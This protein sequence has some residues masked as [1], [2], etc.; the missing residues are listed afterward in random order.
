[1]SVNVTPIAG[2]MA[3]KVGRKVVTRYPN[4]CQGT[5]RRDQL[6]KREERLHALDSTDAK[7][8]SYRSCTAAF[9]G[10]AMNASRSFHVIAVKRRHSFPPIWLN[11]ILV[12]LPSAVRRAALARTPVATLPVG[13][14][15]LTAGVVF[16]TAASRLF[17]GFAF[18]TFFVVFF[19][20]ASLP[21]TVA[22][23]YP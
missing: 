12:N 14:G 19:M 20:I 6:T 21:C 1:M 3:G 17:R 8:F 4:C 7:C 23:P 13:F 22:L 18:V 9:S 5:G 11:I 15:C 16:F 2:L 10:F